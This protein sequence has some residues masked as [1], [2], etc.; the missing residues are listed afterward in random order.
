MKKIKMNDA[1]PHSLKDS[2][3]S[4]KVKIT[5]EEWVGVH[6]LTCNTFGGRGRVGAPRWGLRQMTSG[7]IIHTNLHKP[8]NKLVS[9]WLEHF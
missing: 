4:L 3:A 8:N 1:P 2:N 7:S 6:S 9:V 5:K